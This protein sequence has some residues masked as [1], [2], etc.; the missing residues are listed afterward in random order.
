MTYMA[1]FAAKK[2]VDWKYNAYIPLKTPETS[3]MSLV[4]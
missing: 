3:N 4:I 1:A 2:F